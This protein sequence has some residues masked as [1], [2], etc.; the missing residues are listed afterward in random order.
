MA[1]GDWPRRRQG[2]EARAMERWYE[3]RAYNT[4]VQYGYGTSSEADDYCD[5]LNKNREINHYAAYA[6]PD[7]QAI[8]MG[9]EQNTEAFSL[10]DALAE[11][12]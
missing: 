12:E 8:E 4:Q 1:D 3:F 7:E 2:K 11:T 9:L 6:I 5:H 10:A